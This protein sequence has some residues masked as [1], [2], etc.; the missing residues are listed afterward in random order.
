MAT[1]GK[2]DQSC[3]GQALEDNIMKIQCV[4]EHNGND[5]LLYAVN[6]PG[7]YA[8]GTSREIAMEK[9]V[10]ETCSYL[11]W[12]GECVPEDITVEIVQDASCDLRICDADSDVLFAAEQEPLTMAE[13]LELKALALKSA[14]DFWKLYESIPDKD[15][16]DAPIR[17][18]FYGQVP[19]TATEMYTHTKNVNEYYFAEIDVYADNEG[20]ILDCRRR[21]FEALEVKPDFLENPVIEGSYGESWTLR[22][23]L[24]RF[25]WHD[26]IHARAMYRM[27]VRQFGENAV[28]NVF[29]F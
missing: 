6:L 27:A 26:R 2:N 3:Y 7:A 19:R 20:T 12:K 14:E 21:G 18:T 5:T 24:R 8:R 29:R 9:M 15:K 10:A 28:K 16:S 1:C 11:R 13:Y 4:W 25:I 22:K 23:V 17:R